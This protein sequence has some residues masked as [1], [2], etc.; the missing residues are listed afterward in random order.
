MKHIT[1]LI[2][3]ASS[4]C[5]IRCKYCFYADISTLRKVKIHKRMTNE[6]MTKLIDN[7][8]VDLEGNDELTI[9]FQG[10]EPTLIG[11][12]FY[13]KFI[14]YVE[15]VNQG[16]KVNYSIQTNGMVINYK[17]CELFKKNQFLVGLSIDGPRMFHD[18]TR[19][20]VHG[21]GTY[22]RVL[23]TK[24]L[25][26]HYE[27]TYNVLCVLT[28]KIAQHPD[29][30]FAFIKNE[31]IETIQFIP[32][33]GNFEDDGNDEWALTPE[34]FSSF[35]LVIFKNWF[36]ELKK[37]HY[38]SVKLFEDILNLW[39]NRQ[40]SFCGMLGNCQIQYVIESDGS[41]YPCD[42]YVL[43]K[44]CMGY[45]QEK[46]LKEL[47][48]QPINHSFLCEKKNKSMYCDD[49]PFQRACFG[50]CK[51]MKN[52]MYVNLT[53]T[54]C[55]YRS[56]LCEVVPKINDIVNMIQLSRKS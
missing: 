23:E 50:G 43:D 14:E 34:D 32:C 10:G 17:W 24:K 46:T 52:S 27:I 45:I 12:P 4:L 40:V 25:F 9:A 22:H 36:E 26:D 7:I 53:D 15:K 1:V 21:K 13:E 16:V 42:F 19:E 54:F 30:L 48:S 37:G 44:Y 8:F 38:V 20:T 11:L 31:T 3:P 28:K 33:L 41:V 49:C 55:G 5:N 39:V 47:F 2:K 6:T 18:D 51:R 56:V 35:Y 29:E